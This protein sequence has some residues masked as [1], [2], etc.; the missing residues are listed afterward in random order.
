MRVQKKTVV[1]LIVFLS[2]ATSNLSCPAQLR[3]RKGGIQY[4]SS[5][6][7]DC[8]AATT[9]AEG[10]LTSYHYRKACKDKFNLPTVPAN[11]AEVDVVDCFV[12]PAPGWSDGTIVEVEI[13]CNLNW[14]PW[15]D[16]DNPSGDGDWENIPNF[17]PLNQACANPLAV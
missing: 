3:A 1:L 16:R 5:M 11:V 7:L 13:C 17:L 2:V 10:S 15:L 12:A 6:N 8:P 14:G 4:P 9:A